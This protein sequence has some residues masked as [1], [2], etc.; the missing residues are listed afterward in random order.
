MTYYASICYQLKR[1]LPVQ[2]KRAMI[3]LPTTLKAKLD[4]LRQQGYTANGYIRGSL[5]REL[6]ETQVARKG[7][8]TW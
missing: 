4:A 6:K 8:G 2:T 3:Q 5:E 7:N 1:G